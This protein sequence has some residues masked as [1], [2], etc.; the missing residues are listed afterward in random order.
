MMK[1]PDWVKDAVFYQ[2]FPDR[3]YNGDRNNDPAD[4]AEWDDEPTAHNFFGGDL[5]GIME[6]LDYLEE[7]GVNV[8][9]LNPIFKAPSNHKYDTE[10]YFEIDPQFGS[11]EVLKELVKELH[12]RGMKIILDGVFNHCGER[13]FAFQDVL[14]KGERSK[15][16][17]WFVIEDFPIM[18]EP[19]PNYMCWGGIPNMPEFNTNNPETRKY[20]LNVVRYW[21]EEADIDGWRLDTTEYL[22]PSFVKDIRQVT[23]ETKSD[24]Y[25]VGEVMGIASS[26]F[27]G[28]C[29]DAVMNYKLWE[30]LVD[31]FAKGE[32]NAREFDGRIRFLRGSYPS[33][34]NYAMFN[35]LG[36]HDKPR[37]LSLCKGDVR[38]MKLAIVFLMTYVGAP[39][40]Y[41]GDEIGMEGDGDPDCRRPFIWDEKRQN[42]ELLQLY[43][44]MIRLRKRYP[45]LRRGRFQSLYSH[46]GVY[47]YIRELEDQAIM[48]VL[49]NSDKGDVARIDIE[50][51]SPKYRKAVDLAGNAKPFIIDEN[52]AQLEI[53]ISG[54]EYRVFSL[55]PV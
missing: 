19:E 30:S 16:K 1:P 45:A 42:R 34:A 37:F 50:K 48:I 36:S 27:K 35:L 2:I 12:K 23:K 32:C 54:Y 47:C 44:I 55:L 28:N 24:A 52:E 9:Y 46:N 21:I 51:L 20:L 15:Y 5:K 43:K 39:V 25:V 7:L 31:F 41:Y 29:L 14:K 11:K 10:D 6:K 18:R 13:F 49:N 40:I 22:E 33:W 26:W 8:L 3:F 53:E 38:R 4:V 17:D